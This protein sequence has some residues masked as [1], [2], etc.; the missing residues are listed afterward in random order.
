MCL[1]DHGVSRRVVFYNEIDKLVRVTLWEPE[2]C[3]TGFLIQKLK[4][5]S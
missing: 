3:L 4:E 5:M 2:R 1:Y